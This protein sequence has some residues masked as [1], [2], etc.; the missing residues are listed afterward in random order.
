MG[1][2][3]VDEQDL[4]LQLTGRTLRVY[5]F[6]LK[7]KKP[8]DRKDVQNGAGLSTPS[9]A[10]YHLRKL[11]DMGLVEKLAHGD[12]VVAKIVQVGVTKFYF[13]FR[14]SLVPRYALYASFYIILLIFFFFIY[15]NMSRDIAFLLLCVILFGV[16]SSFF[17]ILTLIRSSP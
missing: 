4:E 5:W 10:E 2:K 14:T 17:E 7:E 13:K 15:E 1:S 8:V 6:L 16:V 3:D 12:Y 9:L 11:M